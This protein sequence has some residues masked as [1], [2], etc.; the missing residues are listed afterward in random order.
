MTSPRSVT[1]AAP[2]VSVVVPA[3]NCERYLGTALESILAQSGPALEIVVV[4]DGSTDGTPDVAQHFVA[5][6]PPG[7]V[8][9]HRQANCGSAAA[10]NRGLALTRGSLIAFLDADDVWL[11]DKLAVQLRFLA[12]H[13]HHGMVCSRWQVQHDDFDTTSIP[14]VDAAECT[15]DLDG[16]LYPTLFLSC[17]VWTSTVVMRR[18]LADAVGTFDTS[19]KRGQDYDYWL[20]ASRLTR[21]ARLSCVTAIYRIH[22]QSVTRTPQK[23]NYEYQVLRKNV[24]SGPHSDTHSGSLTRRVVRVR[25]SQAWRNYWFE[26]YQAGSFRY[27]FRGALQMIRWTPWEAGAWVAAARTAFIPLLRHSPRRS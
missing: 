1:T 22:H 3:F 8:S 26:H 5:T 12:A 11:P 6:A 21:I 13:P 24:Q 15:P 27:C 16:W 2:R 10:R 14:S 19:L 9:L 23:E 7:T 18:S 4:D 25:L 20:R 17:K